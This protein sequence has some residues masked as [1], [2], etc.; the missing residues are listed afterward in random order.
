[1]YHEKMKIRINFVGFSRRICMQ[2]FRFIRKA[3]NFI[4]SR[5]LKITRVKMLAGADRDG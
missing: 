2:V 5:M 3:E 4:N 1:M